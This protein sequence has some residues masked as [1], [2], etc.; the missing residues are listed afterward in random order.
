MGNIKQ[1]TYSHDEEV[2]PAPG[3]GEELDKPVGCPLEQHLQDKD[4]GEDLVSVFQDSANGLP[5]FN[6]DVLKGLKERQQLPVTVLKGKRAPWDPLPLQAVPTSSWPVISFLPSFFCYTPTPKG[7]G[8]NS[9]LSACRASLLPL[10]LS[11]SPE[12]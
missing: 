3:I 4:V 9:G 5:L 1:D 6:I 2:Q 10:R 12:F 11:S 7:W 8:W